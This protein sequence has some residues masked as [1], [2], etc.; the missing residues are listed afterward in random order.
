VSD[1]HEFVEETPGPSRFQR[2]LGLAALLAA[3]G[4]L[5]VCGVITLGK[6]DSSE[7]LTRSVAR[8][9]RK[10]GIRNY[11]RPIV[12]ILVAAPGLLAF[13]VVLGAQGVRRWRGSP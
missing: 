12:P 3:I 11:P 8:T 4:A 10:R 1:S 2:E 5:L 13:A 9:L 6:V 7:S